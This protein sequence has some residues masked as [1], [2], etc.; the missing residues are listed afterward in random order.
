ME[1]VDRWRLSI[2]YDSCSR[3]VFVTAGWFLLQS[4]FQVSVEVPSVANNSKGG[5][6]WNLR[7]LKKIDGM[8][9]MN[10]VLELLSK[11]VTSMVLKTEKK[12]VAKQLQ[13]GDKTILQKLRQNSV[14]L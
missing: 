6:C 9:R 2:N 1:S 3:L 4:W 7:C 14:S 13:N 10:F 5:D 12:Q 11:L 8:F